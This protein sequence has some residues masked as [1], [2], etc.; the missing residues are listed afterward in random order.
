MENDFPNTLPS[1]PKESAPKACGIVLVRLDQIRTDGGTQQRSALDAEIVAEYASLMRSGVEFPP[2]ELW[3]DNEHYW[4]TDGFHRVSAARKCQIQEFQ[5]MI[6]LGSLAEAQWDSF[7]QNARHGLRRTGHDV[8]AIVERALLHPK[9]TQLSNI[10]IAMH[11]GI[12]ETTLRRWR[13][14]LSSPDGGDAVRTVQR[15]GTAY[16][17]HVGRIGKSTSRHRSTRKSPERIVL[18]VFRTAA[19]V[20]KEPI[21]MRCLDTI[22]KCLLYIFVIDF[23]L[24]MLDLVHRMYEASESFR[25]LDFMVHT[26][27]FMSQIVLQIILGTLLPIGLLA[28]TQVFR[29]SDQIRR[30][31]YT[32][33]ASLTLVGIF[34]MRWNVVIGGQL[35]SKSFL[36]YTTYKLAFAAREGLLPAILL[37]IL[38]FLILWGL[39]RLLPPWGTESEMTVRRWLW[40]LHLP[41]RA[42]ARARSAISSFRSLICATAF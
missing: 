42:R 14:R 35:F 33:A 32:L 12:P 34:A 28:A 22:A 3:F 7:G 10:Q 18:V 41:I 20:R 19:Y 23:S 39:L 24:E 27:L 15:K 17:L 5:A 16:Q 11:L 38:P 31:I 4:L 29:F 9:S 21:D 37:L 26:R 36:G 8:A 6:H 2:I 40:P 13:K 30:R 1:P 25:T